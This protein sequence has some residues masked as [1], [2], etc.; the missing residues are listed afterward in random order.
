MIPAGRHGEHLAELVRLR[1]WL[2]RCIWIDPERM[3]GEPCL[4]GT[5]IPVAA[6]TAY[7]DAGLRDR[8]LEAYPSLTEDHI[9]VAEWYASTTDEEG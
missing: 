4:G 5:R 3:G 8:I 7:I 6:V 2:S 9:A 1:R